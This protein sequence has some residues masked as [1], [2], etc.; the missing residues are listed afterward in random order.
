MSQYLVKLLDKKEVAQGTMMFILEKPEQFIYKAGQSGDFKIINPP[1]T[2]EKGN[3][4]TFSFVSAPYESYLAFATRMRESAFKRSLKELPLTTQLELEG[5]YGSMTLHQDVSRPAIFLA[6]GI[7]V[8]PFVSMIKQAIHEGL[9]HQIILFYSNR[10]P[11][12]AAFLTDLQ[13]MTQ[14]S[15][16][17]TLVATMTQL[18]KSS[19]QWLGEKGYITKEM[20]QRY[21]TQPSAGVYYLAG[22]AGFVTGMREVLKE[23]E[24]NEDNIRSE[25]FA[26]Y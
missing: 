25:E 3:I 15:S 13:Q 18:E 24:I 5:P 23:L 8:T 7:G 19:H 1:Y 20:I 10:R 21:L 9:P 16:N 17:F 26:G 22:P 4:R 2:D 12:D 11:E 14:Q 6:G